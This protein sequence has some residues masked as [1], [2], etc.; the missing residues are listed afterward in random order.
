MGGHKTLDVLQR[1]GTVVHTV[2]IRGL[3]RS[4]NPVGFAC[5][6]PDPRTLEFCPRGP[7]RPCSDYFCLGASISLP[8]LPTHRQTGALPLASENPLQSS[9]ELAQ[10]RTLRPTV[11]LRPL[12]AAIRGI[13]QLG[14]DPRNISCVAHGPF[15]HLKN[16]R[17]TSRLTPGHRVSGTTEPAPRSHSRVTVQTSFRNVQ[18]VHCG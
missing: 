14:A 15:E 5:S 13:D 10:R 16:G 4:L 18:L 12:G 7:S 3:L 1:S 8:S 11:P 6:W 9:Q 2:G 17:S